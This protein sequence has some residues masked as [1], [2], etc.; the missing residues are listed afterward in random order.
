MR[1]L[2]GGYLFCF[3]AIAALLLVCA[4][5]AAEPGV[6]AAVSALLSDARTDLAKAVSELD[7]RDIPAALGA[8]EALKFRSLHGDVAQKLESI[9]AAKSSLLKRLSESTG[10]SLTKTERCKIAVPARTVRLGDLEIAIPAHYASAQ[11]LQILE[12]GPVGEAGSLFP[13]VWATFSS[14]GKPVSARL[15]VDGKQV[16]QPEIKG[17]TVFWRPAIT[18]ETMFAIGT[19]TFELHLTDVSRKTVSAAWKCTVGIGAPARNIPIE[20]GVERSQLVLDMKVILPGA[21]DGYRV[22]IVACETAKGERF[23]LYRIYKPGRMSAPYLEGRTLAWLRWFDGSRKQNRISISPKTQAAFPGNELQFSASYSIDGTITEPLKWQVSQNGQT[24]GTSEPTVTLILGMTSIEVIAY[25]SFTNDGSTW[26]LSE[27]RCVGPILPQTQCHPD[28]SGLATPEKNGSVKIS[29]HRTI[30][31]AGKEIELVEGRS[32][33]IYGGVLTV[34]KSR[35]KIAGGSVAPRIEEP[36]ASE[37]RL[38]FSEPGYAEL[39]HDIALS[40]QF[41]DETYPGNSFAPKCSGL[42]GLFQTRCQTEY[43]AF[44]AG[45]LL[46]TSRNIALKKLVMH[47][48][49]SKREISPGQPL[50]FSWELGSSALFPQSPPLAFTGVRLSI[51]QKE[52]DLTVQITGDAFQYQLTHDSPFS[53][54]MYVRPVAKIHSE[55]ID[56]V[57]EG[58]PADSWKWIPF[59]GAFPS[60]VRVEIDPAQPPPI[61]EGET[62]AFSGT[63]LPLEGMGTGKIDAHENTIDLLDGY[64]VV[65]VNEVSWFGSLSERRK[66]PVSSNRVD[67]NFGFTPQTGSGSYVVGAE[68]D[69]T[70]REKNTGTEAPVRGSGDVSLLVK[71][72]LTIVSPFDGFGYPLGAEIEVVTGLDGTPEEWRNISWKLNGKPWKPDSE[73]TPHR[74]LLD[75]KGKNVLEAELRVPSST[76]PNAEVTLSALATFT[77]VPVEVVLTPTRQLNAFAPDL[78]QHVQL[79]VTLGTT[80]IHEINKPVP[81]FE[82]GFVAELAGI[83]WRSGF[84]PDQNGEFMLD[85]NEFG[86]TARFHSPGACSAL[87]TITLRIRCTDSKRED[88]EELIFRIAAARADLWAF[89][90]PVWKSGIEENLPSRAVAKAKRTFT[91]RSGTFSFVGRTFG[92]SSSGIEPSVVLQPALPGT[93]PLRAKSIGFAWKGPEENAGTGPKYAPVMG[94]DPRQIVICQARLGFASGVEI[95]FEPVSKEVDVEQ[96]EDLL[97][98]GVEPRAFTIVAGGKQE[99]VCKLYKPGSTD[100]ALAME[101]LGGA[102]R[103]ELRDLSWTQQGHALGS[104]NPFTYRPVATEDSANAITA[105]AVVSLFEREPEA[106]DDPDLFEFSGISQPTI[107]APKIELSITDLFGPVPNENKKNPG[108]YVHFN[109]DNDNFN[110]KPGEDEFTGKPMPDY[111][112]TDHVEGE[113]DLCTAKIVF[114]NLNVGVVSLRRDNAQLR[115]WSSPTKEASSAILVTDDER[116][117]NL[118]ID[119]EREQ[120]EEIKDRLWVEGCGPDSSGLGVTYTYRAEKYSTADWVKYTFLSAA[121]GRQPTPLEERV[122]KDGM[123]LRIVGCEYSITGGPDKRYNCI[124]WSVGEDTVFYEGVI[125]DPPSGTVSIDAEY[126]NKDDKFT[127]DDDLDP[128]YKQKGFE[129]ITSAEEQDAEH[130]DVVYFSGNHAARKKNCS[131]GKKKWIIFE[132]KLGSNMRIEHILDQISHGNYGEPCRYY[133][134]SR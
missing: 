34:V 66:K 3:Y 132:S 9:E 112:E 92:W 36:T 57:D 62:I 130:A 129:R 89:P 58:F 17:R 83:E 10:I 67:W 102:F 45:V 56:Q 18:A 32:I 51:A 81:W 103:G 109:I 94:A 16:S 73:S 48:N 20:E 27:S 72:G 71:P 41:G 77:V 80:P 53:S 124:A 52:P 82:E 97:S 113:N 111:T 114:P 104:G 38:L 50:D 121:C 75:K 118:A 59:F 7:E 87:A 31:N 78:E 69:M 105:K 68:A 93:L 126:G 91:T 98:V 85:E 70:A 120:F 128:F 99:L 107:L 24:W 134:K 74:L 115:V 6:S 117:W 90:P 21:P 63:I 110:V 12:Y 101:L 5:L 131:D 44:P 106:S 23:F 25:L 8:I 86:G 46:G 2:F 13:D 39:V 64:E 127:Y 49:G 84:E 30:S 14:D 19:H 35:W 133:R 22:A 123:G 122:L 26:N 42:F 116:H 88:S 95:M 61:R 1:R 60:L 29:G 15:L 33:P 11:P 96:L 43:D 76:E 125:K 79:N 65:G 4:P 40:F 108:A 28:R 100:G 37:T 54:G 47:V 119:T 55:F